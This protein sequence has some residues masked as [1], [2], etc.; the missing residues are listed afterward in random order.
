MAASVLPVTP[1]SEGEFK[2]AAARGPIPV[3]LVG[4]AR[5]RFARGGLPTVCCCCCC[6]PMLEKCTGVFSVDGGGLGG[7][8][9]NED[10]LPANAAA[11]NWAAER[12]ASHKAPGDPFETAA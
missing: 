10:P 1:G 9:P 5:Q 12:P 4:D 8:R 7:G 3:F 6:C 2:A 11:E